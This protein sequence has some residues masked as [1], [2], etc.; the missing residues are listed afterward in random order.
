MIQ[1]REKRVVQK[2]GKNRSKMSEMQRDT[3][4]KIWAEQ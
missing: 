3:S 2:N 4:D 1:W